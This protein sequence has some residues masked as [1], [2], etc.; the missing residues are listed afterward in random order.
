MIQELNVETSGELARRS[1]QL[2]KR[3]S[4]LKQE[5]GG[6]IPSAD[7][8][9]DMRP[10]HFGRTGVNLMNLSLSLI[11]LADNLLR[12]DWWDQHGQDGLSKERKMANATAYWTGVS[13]GSFHVHCANEEYTIRMIA[14]ALDPTQEALGAIWEIRSDLL[15][16]LDATSDDIKGYFSLMSRL[17]NTIHNSGVFRDP[18]GED[19][20]VEFGGTRYEFKHD[21]PPNCLT[22]DFLIDRMSDGVDIILQVLSHPTVVEVDHIEDLYDRLGQHQTISP[23][24]GVGGG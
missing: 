11:H 7:P 14:K 22:P 3:C 21:Y 12:F 1:W 4:G 18:R 6:L 24:E 2:A 16:A 19:R 10:G 15:K 20:T 17:R 9:N 13:F 23:G 8:D 5:I